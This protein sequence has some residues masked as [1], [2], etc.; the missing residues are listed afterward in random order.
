MDD[1][2]RFEDDPFKLYLYLISQV[3]P[4]G[5]D[6]ELSCI[7]H[8]L[9]QDLNAESATKRLVE[10]LLGLVVSMAE[11]YPSDRINI[12]DLI[13]SGNTGLFHAVEA[14]R[15]FHDDR[16]STLA[17]PYIER[18]LAEAVGRSESSGT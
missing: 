7:E 8:V 5:L 3:P 4:L 9:A 1:V 18:T 10:A 12:L 6:E 2:A 15:D 17:Q 13:E 11:R 16:F 14:L